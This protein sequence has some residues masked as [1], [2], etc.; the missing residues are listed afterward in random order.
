MTFNLLEMRCH[1]NKDGGGNE[2]RNNDAIKKT[3][4]SKI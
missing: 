2:A 4:F 3:A 1:G